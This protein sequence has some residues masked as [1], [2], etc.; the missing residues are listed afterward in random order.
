VQNSNAEQQ[1]NPGYGSESHSEASLHHFF[2]KMASE[3]LTSEAKMLS[4]VAM[5]AMSSDSF[6]PWLTVARSF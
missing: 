2:H 1:D 4:A 6:E 5:P 3:N